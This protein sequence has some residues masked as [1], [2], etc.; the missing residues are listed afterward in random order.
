MFLR[1]WPLDIWAVTWMVWGAFGSLWI[2]GEQVHMGSSRGRCLRQDWA[3]LV[4][5]SELGWEG[6]DKATVA[7]GI[8]WWVA[9]GNSERLGFQCARKGRGWSV[10]GMWWWGWVLIPIWKTHF[11]CCVGDGQRAWESAGSSAGKPSG[12]LSWRGW[13][14]WEDS[15]GVRSYWIWG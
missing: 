6:W 11:A 7:R 8:L 3:V 10:C 14:Q 2:P 5:M 15:R 4:E 1:I 13:L 12:L 9:V